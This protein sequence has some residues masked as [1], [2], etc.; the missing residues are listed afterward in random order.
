MSVKKAPAKSAFFLTQMRTLRSS[1]GI[2]TLQEINSVIVGIPEAHAEALTSM[3]TQCA[4]SVGFATASEMRESL[5]VF[6]TACTRG[7]P[8]PIASELAGKKELKR[9]LGG[10]FEEA[11]GSAR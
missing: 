1:Q 4:F 10:E 8:P 5:G 3:A 7:H 9:P 11:R 2:W 6:L